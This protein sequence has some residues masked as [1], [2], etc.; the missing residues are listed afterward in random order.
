MED[1]IEWQL[2]NGLHYVEVKINQ[3]IWHK[4]IANFMFKNS[5]ENFHN[6][7]ELLAYNETIKAP[8]PSETNLN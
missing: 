2:T 7:M 5:M 8:G 4:F 6:S 1:D 3:I